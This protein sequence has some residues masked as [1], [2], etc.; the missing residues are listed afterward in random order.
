MLPNTYKKYLQQTGHNSRKLKK[1]KNS[2]I[3]LHMSWTE[4]TSRTQHFIWMGFQ[5]ISVV[6]C[7]G[8]LNFQNIWSSIY[9]ERLKKKNFFIL[10]LDPWHIEIQATGMA[11]PDLFNP[12][13][14]A[15][16]QIST[17]TAMWAAAIRFLTHRTI[18]GTPQKYISSEI[19]S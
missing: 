2:S 4:L 13:H 3:S 17:A 15:R 8:K 12:L 14:Q 7:S 9:K 6:C 16:D 11:T 1:K 10:W 5:N 18:V 19:S